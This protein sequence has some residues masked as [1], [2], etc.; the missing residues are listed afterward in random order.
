MKKK[1]EVSPDEIE[2]HFS[3]H[4][5]EPESVIHKVMSDTLHV[6]VH[7]IPPRPERE[8]WTLFTTGMSEHP[9]AVPD[10][11]QAPKLAEVL[12]ALPPA[13]Q[14]DLLKTEVERWAWPMKWLRLVAIL[15]HVDATWLG[16]RHTIPN[17]DPP[18]PFA[19]GTKLAVWMLL[20]PV[21]V[22]EEARTV[23]L[24]DG[25]EVALLQLHALHA[26]E[27]ALKLDKGSDALL[28]ALVAAD[29]TEV[30]TLDRR[31]VARKKRFGIF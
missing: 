13:W 27:L 2:A 24:T 5:G 18:E 19:P 4:F 29:V 7:I 6:D 10:G 26:D 16:E 22:A 12:I 3:A 11:V 1:D 21:S 15:P 28:D 23:K 25:R 30:L 9:M 31:S 8:W 20:P 17:G 14:M